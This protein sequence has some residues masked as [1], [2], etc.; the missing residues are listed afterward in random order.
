MARIG[1]ISVSCYMEGDGTYVFPYR[2]VE[3]EEAGKVFVGIC[4]EDTSYSGVAWYDD[5]DL[6]VNSD[7]DGLFNFGGVNTYTWVQ[8]MTEVPDDEVAIEFPISIANGGT[9]AT[10]A[11]EAL[12]NLGAAS[13]TALDALTDT[14]AGKADAS[15]THSEYAT[16]AALDALEDAIG[17]KANA[18]HSHAISDVTNLQSTLD[19][20]A[21][22][23]HDHNTAY[24]AL[25]HA[26]DDRYYTETEIDS[27]VSTLNASISGKAASSHTHVIADVANL[28]TELDAL[29]D[30]VDGKA[31]AS[32]THSDYTLTSHNHDGVYAETDH[33][34]NYA[35]SSH[36]H[37]VA[38][39]AA[40]GFMSAADKTKL[41][42][43]ATGAEVNQ[44]AFSNVVI[45]ATT[46]AADA[47]TD[48]LTLVAGSN[49]TIIPDAANDKIT[50]SATDTDTVYTHPSYTA[51]TG[52]P[53]A[54][55]TPG[56]GGTFS[57]TQPVS[58]GSGHI[59]AMNS[60]TV[61][62]P[63]TA[64]TTSAAGLMSAADKTKLN[65]IASGANAYTLPTAGSS[66]GGVKTT[67]T[68]TSNSG[69][70]ACPI[71]SGVPYYKDTNTTYNLGSFGVTA[72]AA[73]LNKLDG[74]TATTAEL[75][76]VDGVTSNIQTQLDGKASSSHT[77]SYLPLSGGTM[78]GNLVMNG[79]DIYTG[80]IYFNENGYGKGM[81]YGLAPN[82]STYV[83][84]F[85]ACSENGNCVVGWGNYDRED[86]NTNIYG[87]GINIYSNVG[88]Y[89]R[90]TT[91]H[92][93]KTTDASPTVDNDVALIVGNRS[94]NHLAIDG[95]EIIAKASGTTPGTLYL[96]G[97][98]IYFTSEQAGISMKPYFAKG[99][100]FSFSGFVG[101]GFVTSSKTKVYFMY[102]LTRPLIGSPTITASGSFILRQD[103]SYTH[104][105]SSSTYVT[106]TSIEAALISGCGIRVVATFSN[107]TNAVNNAAVGVSWNGSISFS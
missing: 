24:A 95:N 56:F 96:V 22:I 55:Q 68:V 86:G 63:N 38:T 90:D 5:V 45:G 50:I 80:D 85:Q 94:G 57:V 4:N 93:T 39:T 89:M 59:T 21:S 27:M 64:A 75:N 41:S 34:H 15:H 71:I 48:T 72:T 105:S 100:S 82:G 101:S 23:T 31:A 91:L 104:G 74:V 40:N 52:V 98:D 87:N 102:P 36:S 33:T 19:G 88:V 18:T 66:L 11:A 78:T 35:A 58:D 62:I 7:L 8:T 12:T 76:Y 73:E 103:G 49:V 37:S 83:Q 79:K 10:T 51:R 26:H 13:T 84:N 6:E 14:V 67:S 65:G 47:E 54:N 44:N 2:L 99:D 53:T 25:S 92:L 20:K 61:T 29:S 32:H 97:Q 106:P 43:I 17:D 30:T 16:V 3:I 42:G 60:R 1:R 9:G 46:I 77:H 69:Y 28:Q 107:T 81:I 70:T